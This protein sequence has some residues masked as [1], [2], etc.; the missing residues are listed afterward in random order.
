MPAGKIYRV[1]R[2]EEEEEYI[3]K[4]FLKLKYYYMHCNWDHIYA[5]CKRRINDFPRN[6]IF[7]LMRALH[8][9]VFYKSIDDMNTMFKVQEALLDEITKTEFDKID[10]DVDNFLYNMYNEYSRYPRIEYKI[11]L[12]KVYDKCYKNFRFRGDYVI[13][14]SK[15]IRIGFCS[16]MLYKSS[17]GKSI[18]GLIMNL[19][20]DKYEIYL[21]NFI[22][23]DDLDQVHK[24]MIDHCHKYYHLREHS[25]DDARNIIL[26]DELD[27][28]MFCNVG[29]EETN[30]YLCH[31]R[32]APVQLIHAW[33]FGTTTASKAIDYVI[34]M[35]EEVPDCQKNYVEKTLAMNN[36]SV[37]Y[38][39]PKINDPMGVGHLFNHSVEVPKKTRSDFN[40]SDDIIIY[41]CI[42]QVFKFDILYVET[43][44]KIVENDRKSI[45]LLRKDDVSHDIFIDSLCDY[46]G[47]R[48]EKVRHRIRFVEKMDSTNYLQLMG[49]CDVHLD[50]EPFGMGISAF[51]GFAIE[52]P[53]VTKPSR[54]LRGR[55]VYIL[56]KKMGIEDISCD[57]DEEYENKAF[58][59]ANNVDGYRD[60]IVELIR[61]NKHKIFENKDVISEYDDLFMTFKDH[62]QK[63]K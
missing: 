56:Y 34:I 30:T 45:L 50:P 20:K 32:L 63:M 54:Y 53:I 52:V 40:L 23:R 27:I 4:Y 62:I 38:Y 61:E 49:L 18:M 7:Y 39:E 13:N 48:F 10:A 15:K 42:Q 43:L 12:E 44:L 9:N 46:F 60:K 16:Q 1:P 14:D 17:V 24:L 47:E 8:S 35:N 33:G 29:D 25:Y 31:S 51:D 2:D 55:M 3:V 58:E 22:R 6:P 11:L 5:M 26:T 21:Y 41:G 57:T 37:Y 36:L 28:L 59:L 19:P